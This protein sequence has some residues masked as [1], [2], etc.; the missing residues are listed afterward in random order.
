MPEAISQN[1]SILEYIINET[2]IGD[3]IKLVNRGGI[4]KIE[5]DM[6]SYIT[7]LYGINY[8]N[9]SSKRIQRKINDY[10]R[11]FVNI[12]KKELHKAI[13]N[14]IIDLKPSNEEE[15]IKE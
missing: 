5:F 4:T 8:K 1:K 14:K 13:T 11:Y 6:F 10:I 12:Y 7:N 15:D 3:Y 2:D 9:I